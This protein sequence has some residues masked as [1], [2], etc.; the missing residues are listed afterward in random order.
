MYVC[1]QRKLQHKRAIFEGTFVEVVV[2]DDD[3]DNALAVLI[4]ILVPEAVHPGPAVLV[5]AS[6]VVVKE[7]GHYLFLSIGLQR[8]VNAQTYRIMITIYPRGVLPSQ[9]PRRLGRQGDTL[10]YPAYRQDDDDDDDDD[11]WS[12]ETNSF[13]EYSWNLRR[14][15][16]PNSFP[17]QSKIAATILSRGKYGFTSASSRL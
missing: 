12:I 17:A 14:K 15:D 3:G 13:I 8:L 16:N 4:D 11:N 5:L 10:R 1:F 6:I 7:D 9:S 2:I